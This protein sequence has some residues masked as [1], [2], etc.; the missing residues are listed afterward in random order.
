MDSTRNPYQP[1][2]ADLG[3]GQSP[4]GAV[5]ANNWLRLGTLVVDYFGF[6][7]CGF[8]LGLGLAFGF[9]E[10]GTQLLERT[11]DFILGVVV[12]TAY[13]AVFES[14]WGRTPGKFVF[15]TVVVDESG[16]KPGPGQIIK[17]TLCR[18][19]PFEAFSFFGSR[20]W[21]DSISRTRVVRTRS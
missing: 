5:L 19:I 12:V 21:H 10:A 17:R 3:S 14:I 11:P 13:Y 8:L 7:L 1:P 4:H 6:M 16:G 15:G 9:G 20:G 18:F 2:S